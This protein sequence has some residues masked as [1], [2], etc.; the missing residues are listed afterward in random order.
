MV[1][2]HHDL[3]TVIPLQRIRVPFLDGNRG[4][5]RRS[6]T[7]GHD[8]D[9]LL[10]RAPSFGDDVLDILERLAVTHD[11]ERTVRSG[12]REQQQ[13]GALPDRFGE[14]AARLPHDGRIQIVEKEVERAGVDGE[15]REHVTPARKRDHAH[16]VAGRHR[17]QPPHLLLHAREPV[18]L[19]VG[20]KHRER[21]VE[22]EHHVD[23]A[24]PNDRLL[25]PPPRPRDADSHERAR[26]G[27]PRSAPAHRAHRVR[28]K[29]TL[30]DLGLTEPRE[31]GAAL[32]VRARQEPD[33][34]DREDHRERQ[35]PEI[36]EGDHHAGSG[37]RHAERSISNESASTASA[38]GQRY[39]SVNRT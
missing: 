12:T 20:R 27:E 39:S 25:G 24:R 31:P 29:E 16:T 32:A 10:R 38:N 28:R 36:I 21:R 17:A 9:P 5:R 14:R 8:A 22:R 37:P 19:V 6:E 13:V 1:L 11:D 3:A 4:A 35:Q 23:A 15:R 34:G 7:N 30:H 2:R 18:R 33:D 26:R